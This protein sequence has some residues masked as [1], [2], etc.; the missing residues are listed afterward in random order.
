M[1]YVGFVYSFV[2]VQS[3]KLHLSLPSSEVYTLVGGDMNVK[4]K[5]NNQYY[6]NACAIRGSRGLNYL[7]NQIYR[8]PE[9]SGAEKGSD[10]LNYIVNAKNYNEYMH[11]TFGEP[12]YKLIGT[13]ANILANRTEFVK[14]KNGIYTIVNLNAIYSGHV[15]M[16][17]NGKCI[18]GLYLNPPGGVLKIEIWDLP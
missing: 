14:G 18:S 10:N 16:I 8:I 4:N 6:Q 1:C 15:D 9:I 12:T 5:N 11:R 13:A 2:I 17:I 3:Y 7:S